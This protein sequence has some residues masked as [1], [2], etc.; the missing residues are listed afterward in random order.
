MKRAEAPN[1]V[2]S[3]DPDDLSLGEKLAK[4]TEG[5]TVIWIVEGRDEDGRVRYKEVRVA[6]RE[7][8]ASVDDRLGHREKLDSDL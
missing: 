7:P 3:V 1:E 8:S 6:R 4:D 5:D 2:E